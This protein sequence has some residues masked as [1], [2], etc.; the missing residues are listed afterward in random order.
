METMRGESRRWRRDGAASIL[1]RVS[2]GTKRA[3]ERKTREHPENP[4]SRSSLM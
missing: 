2:V 3:E 4:Q 1:K